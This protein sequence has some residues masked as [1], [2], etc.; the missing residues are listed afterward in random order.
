MFLKNAH[1]AAQKILMSTF[2]RFIQMIMNSIKQ[3]CN[4]SSSCDLVLT[5]ACN[6]FLTRAY[7]IFLTRA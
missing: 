6:D 7:T 3:S 4:H 2:D 5:R 1:A